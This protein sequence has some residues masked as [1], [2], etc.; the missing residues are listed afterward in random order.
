MPILYHVIRSEEPEEERYRS[1]ASRERPPPDDLPETLRLWTGISAWNTEAQARKKAR[2]L[3]E[4]GFYLGD[5]I[6]E[7]NLP[8]SGSI[9]WERTT[10]ARGHHTVW[11]DPSE[12][13]A[14]VQRLIGV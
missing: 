12:I 7:L 2:D 11:G 8:A 1:N 13:K 14:C 3:E 5:L 9:Q 6:A 4:M 10:G